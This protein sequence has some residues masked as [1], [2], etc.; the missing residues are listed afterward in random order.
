M[1]LPRLMIVDDEPH[2]LTALARQLRHQLRDQALHLELLSDPLQARERL[3]ERPYA[4][5]ISDYRMPGLDGV[6]LLGEL[7][8]R[9]PECVRV[10]LSGQVDQAGL[11][12]A[13]N[14]AGVHRFIA[15]PWQDAELADEVR[16]GIALH[17]AQRAGAEAQEA[18][19]EAAGQL[20]PQEREARRLER[21]EPGLTEVRRDASGAVLMDPL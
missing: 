1:S 12:G 4:M 16:A 19:A 2:V 11:R 10:L 17:A 14:E 3:R 18:A 13:I 5:V 8:R 6:T 7:R 21:L 20:S 15:K 9:Q